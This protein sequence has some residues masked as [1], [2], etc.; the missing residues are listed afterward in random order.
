LSNFQLQ[1]RTFLRPL[2]GGLV[3]N[4]F[5]V[6]NELLRQKMIQ[7]KCYGNSRVI[8]DHPAEVTFP[9]VYL[10]DDLRPT[11]EVIARR[12]LRSFDSP[13]LLVPSARQTT[14]G[15]RA[16]SMAAATDQDCLFVNNIPASKQDFFSISLMAD[17]NLSFLLFCSA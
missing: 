15:D 7:Y 5:I 10:A 6:A 1:Q 12:R 9:P 4:F 8:W 13:P 3:G 2:N 16:F 11:S 14:L 17:L